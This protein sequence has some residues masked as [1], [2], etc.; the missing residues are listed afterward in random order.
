MVELTDGSGDLPSGQGLVITQVVHGWAS[1][2]CKQPLGVRGCMGAWV[3]AGGRGS[4]VTTPIRLVIT[5]VVDVGPDNY[6]LP[7][8]DRLTR[9]ITGAAKAGEV[10][11]SW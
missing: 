9:C 10:N 6:P 3:C 8:T 4:G 1:F 5:T 7:L 11:L 2:K